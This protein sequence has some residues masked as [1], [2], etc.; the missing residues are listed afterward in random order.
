MVADLEATLR[1][2]HA[3]GR[4][5]RDSL[6]PMAALQDDYPFIRSV[7]RRHGVSPHDAD[8]LAQ[9]V[10][11]VMWRRR[12]DFDEARPLRPWLGGIAARLAISFRRRKQRL[13]PTDMEDTSDP[14]PDPEADLASRRSR[15]LVTRALATLPEKLRTAL[16]CCDVEGQSVR[17]FTQ[18]QGIPLHTGYSRLRL[19]RQALGR[20][21]RRLM[22]D[23]LDDDLPTAGLG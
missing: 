23:D 10:L 8:D 1:M 16:V 12:A 21:L 7:L 11:L 6:P 19:G 20:N 17:D 3:V 22:Q 18:A 15:A 4:A 14:G 5:T 2:Q 9:E 13:T